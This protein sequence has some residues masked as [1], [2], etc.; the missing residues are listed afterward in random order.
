MAPLKSLE[1]EHPVI[2][3]NFQTF[4]ASHGIFSVED[5]LIHDLDELAGSAQQHPTSEKLKQGITEVH[6]IIDSQHQPWLN[7][8][9]LLDDALHFKHVLSTG[10]EGIDLLL[11]G[12]LREGHVTEL[13]GPS[14][15]GKTQVCLLSAANV[16]TKHMGTVVYLDTGNSF[17]PE[18]IVHFVGDISDHA[19]DQAGQRVFQKVMN[20]ILCHPVF[21][22]FTMFNLLHRLE[23][24]L[25]SQM[26]KGEQVRLLVVDSISSLITPILGNSGSQGRALM[27]SAGYLLK[28][29]AHEHNL[30]VL[31][32][33]HTVGGEKGIPKPAL[34][35]TWKSIPHVRL[36]LSGDQ[37]NSTRTISVLRHPSM[38][39]GKS[40]RFT[41]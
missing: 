8:L 9:E 37:G 3:S 18:R 17:S 2:D 40:T 38:A 31:V 24:S 41:I 36:L 12:G 1:A 33:N 23:F 21:D 27:I 20:N 4:C 10:C 16:A 32:T 39:S 11:R 34:G 22:I 14:S 15:S 13:V 29:L 25:P 30:A 5:F 26:R 7:G 19:F 28:K 35:Q 6:S